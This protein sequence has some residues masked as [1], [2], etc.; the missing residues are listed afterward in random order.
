MVLC[1]KTFLRP[2]SLAFCL[3]AYL[4]ISERNKVQRR[5]VANNN[6]MKYNLQ[7][8]NDS[9]K[10]FFVIMVLGQHSSFLDYRSRI[11]NKRYVLIDGQSVLLSTN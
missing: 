1:F 3:L 8:G 7:K 5:H 9:P 2:K 10:S 11:I 6:I 4:Q